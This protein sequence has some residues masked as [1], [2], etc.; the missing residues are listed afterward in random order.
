MPRKPS[1]LPGGVR[2][3]DR[4]S[5]G[6]LM[7]KLPAERIDEVLRDTGR[8]SRRQRQLPARLMVYYVIALTLYLEISSEAV[9]SWLLEGLNWLGLS[10]PSRW[11]SRAGL[12]QAR[13]RLGVEPLRQLYEQT[14]G[15]IATA[16]TRG[17][18]YHGFR[19]VSLDG[20][21][22]EVADSPDNEATFGRPGSGRGRSGFP[23]I[24]C[25]CLAE[26]GTH[27]LFGAQ[28]AGYTTSEREL[29]SRVVTRL[30]PEMLC[31]ADRGF[32]GFALWQ[33]AHQTGAQLLWRV[34]FQVCLPV[35]KRLADGS[36][37]SKIY[38]R[39]YDRKTDRRGVW[40][41]VVDY[42]LEEVEGSEPSYRLL[43]TLL[44]PAQA[45]A[46]QLAVLYHERWEIELA[47]AELKTQLRG[48]RVVLRSQGPELVLQEFYGLL[49][50]HYIVRHLLHEA[51]SQ[52][53]RDPDELS[54]LHAVRVLRRKLPKLAASPP[55]AVAIAS[56]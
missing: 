11:A 7:T 56:A 21:S 23:Q 8:Q 31:L 51:A 26:V 52:A 20:T 16:H 24:R 1:Q 34:S 4:L 46:A 32:F 39:S 9:L 14:V 44:D 22:L 37:L 30:Q 42:R 43:T 18:W 41:R 3:S 2:L 17:A 53:D 38:P 12:S 49:L 29:A 40:V 33:Q 25:V 55:S 19:L 27:V 10:V 48:R 36:Y 47:F 6:V 50:A 28:V 45:P 13:L 5:L 54:F 35:L 15:P